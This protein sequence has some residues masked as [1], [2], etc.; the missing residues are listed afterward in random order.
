MNTKT[1]AFSDGVNT[2]IDDTVVQ[3]QAK[4]KAEKGF[5]RGAQKQVQKPE[6]SDTQLRIKELQ[7]RAD[8]RARQNPHQ[9]R[10]PMYMVAMAAV[11]PLEN[12][13][14]TENIMNS[15]GMLVG[16]SIIG[17]LQF[18]NHPI[19]HIDNRLTA[20]SEEKELRRLVR[21]EERDIKDAS[22]ENNTQTFTARKEVLGESAAAQ[23][24]QV[25]DAELRCAMD[26]ALYN[27][28]TVEHA[29]DLS[30]F[31]D[32]KQYAEAIARVSH[33]DAIDD[34]KGVR[35]QKTAAEYVQD[36]ITT[37]PDEDKIASDMFKAISQD[38]GELGEHYKAAL[39]KCA[40]SFNQVKERLEFRETSVGEL[41]PVAAVIRDCM[42]ANVVRY[43]HCDFDVQAEAKDLGMDC[44]TREEFIDAIKTQIAMVSAD[45]LP[46]PNFVPDVSQKSDELGL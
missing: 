30:D 28:Y 43:E 16:A 10:D 32:L 21:Q 12:G 41:P 39:N 13:L 40:S 34:I 23:E 33:G 37:M 22:R 19:K 29:S 35:E 36:I 8:R 25:A 6:L 27:R 45:L 26:A 1:E 7:E 11:Q 44:T 18:I 2:K 17:A 24:G 4:P 15:F 14:T 38:G 46:D 3:A 9:H 5:A 42:A 31:S 20:H